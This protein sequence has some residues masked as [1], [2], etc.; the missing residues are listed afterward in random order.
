MVRKS[1]PKHGFRYG[2][3]AAGLSVTGARICH[4]P[5]TP[6]KLLGALEALDAELAVGPF[7][8]SAAL[9]TISGPVA[10]VGNACGNRAA[11]A[12]LKTAVRSP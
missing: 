7:Q 10:A 9:R 8:C 5:A 4:F 3:V 11:L 2:L 6:D 1:G 12:A